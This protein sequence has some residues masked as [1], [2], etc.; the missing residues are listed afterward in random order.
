MSLTTFL[1]I[2][3]AVIVVLW[4]ITLSSSN[5]SN[6]PKQ[7][8]ALWCFAALS[9]VTVLSYMCFMHYSHSKNDTFYKNTDGCVLE[10]EGLEFS[11]GKTLP[12][13]SDSGDL[14]LWA[15]EEGDLVLKTDADGCFLNSSRLD[16]PLCVSD[17]ENTNLFHVVNLCEGLTLHDG[18]NLTIIES[19]QDKRDTLIS[20]KYEI[21]YAKKKGLRNLFKKK[22][23]RC[24]FVFGTG[25]VLTDTVE[26]SMFRRGRNLFNLLADEVGIGLNREVL[27]NCYLMRDHFTIDHAKD[28]EPDKAVHL[29]CNNSV[30]QNNAVQIFINGQRI[31]NYQPHDTLH[32]VD[33]CYFYTGIT[34]PTYKIWK[35]KREA[36]RVFVTY[37]NPLRYPFPKDAAY[38]RNKLFLTTNM[39]EIIDRQDDFNYFYRIMP[40]QVDN[41]P[42]AANGILSYQFDKANVNISPN[43]SDL[44]YGDSVRSVDAT[45]NG[46][47]FLL[48]SYAR[49][50]KASPLADVSYQLR[51]HDFRTD[52]I[53]YQKA[54]RHYIILLIA[55][56]CL[57]LILMRTGNNN[58]EDFRSQSLFLETAV[59]LV[60]IGFLTVRMIMLWRLH[61]FPPIEN[62]STYEYN[63]LLNPKYFRATWSAIYALLVLRVLL[64]LPSV[65]NIWDSIIEKFESAV[66][67]IWEGGTP[68]PVTYVIVALITALIIGFMYLLVFVGGTR[69][70]YL[71]TA[72]T[73]VLLCWITSII[74][75]H[76]NELTKFQ[77][78]LL[79]FLNCGIFLVLSLIFEAG[80]ILPVI[81]FFGLMLL[82]ILFGET[83]GKHKLA[84]IVV[85]FVTVSLS[86]FHLLAAKQVSPF[87]GKGSHRLEARMQAMVYEPTELFSDPNV[88]FKSRGNYMQDILNATSNY[89]FIGNHINYRNEILKKE[90]KGFHPV[91]E[92]TQK[93]VSYITQTRDLSLLRYLNFEH[94][95]GPVICLNVLLFILLL[96]VTTH[97]KPWKEED[98][99]R[100]LSR[101]L[102]LLTVLFLL[103]YSLY[104]ALV[105]VNALVFVGLDFPFLTLTS[106]A[107]P[108]AFIIFLLAIIW[109]ICSKENPE[110][111]LTEPFT[112]RTDKQNLYRISTLALSV[113]LIATVPL[114]IRNA[115]ALKTLPNYFV[116]MR[117]LIGFIRND[118]NPELLKYQEKHEK[119]FRSSDRVV[120]DT[121]LKKGVDSLFAANILSGCKDSIYY[122]PKDTAFI[123]SVFKKATSYSDLDYLVYA[124]KISGHY[125]FAGN[126]KF[127]YLGA[128]FEKQKEDI[129]HGDLLAADTKESIKPVVN[130]HTLNAINT[131]Q[132][133]P[134]NENMNEDRILYMSVFNLPGRYCYDGQN[135]LIYIIDDD[136]PSYTIIP[137]GDPS[138][139]LDKMVLSCLVFPKDIL[140]VGERSIQLGMTESHYLAKTIHYN[141]STQVIYPLGRDFT[142]A[143]N[144][145]TMLKNSY[146]AYDRINN[147]HGFKSSDTTVQ[148]SLD[149]ELLTDV[150][151]YCRGQESGGVTK[152]GTGLTVAAV[153]GN[154][155][156]RLLADY[157][158]SP[159]HRNIDPNDKEK[160]DEIMRNSV[161]NGER[162]AER[163]ALA[164][165]NISMLSNGPGSTI[166]P[167]LFAAIASQTNLDWPSFQIHGNNNKIDVEQGSSYWHYFGDYDMTAYVKKNETRKEIY[168]ERF[169]HA[170]HVDEFIKTSNN[171]FFGSVL[172]LGTALNEH[173]NSLTEMTG[174]YDKND[175]ASFP[176]FYFN[177]KWYKF[178]GDFIPTLFRTRSTLRESALEQ[179]LRFNFQYNCANA[180]YDKDDT[181][182]VN[183]VQNN[184]YMTKMADFLGID[185]PNEYVF[186]ETSNFIRK[187]YAKD[188][189]G[190]NKSDI[191]TQFLNIVRGGDP[192]RTSPLSMAEAFLRIAQGNSAPNLLTYCERDSAAA[193]AKFY[194]PGYSSDNVYWNAM[195]NTLFKGLWDVIAVGGGT[196]HRTGVLMD[197]QNS[198]AAKHIYLYGKTGTCNED[199]NHHYAFIL[200]NQKLNGSEP[201]DRST[202]KVYVVYFG[203]YD[204]PSNGHSA[205]QPVTKAIIE[206][207]INSETF[208][209]YWYGKN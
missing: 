71:K 109:P 75:T 4:M 28:P 111:I 103:V 203:F 178:N 185:R 49:Q 191:F 3:I 149:Y 200:T 22:K 64:E 55:F 127:S 159:S 163:N 192:V 182:V 199:K 96:I 137:Q 16:V 81:G 48:H 154:G 104:L 72:A 97:T 164:N 151:H 95:S 80:L 140:K 85:V 147:P 77:K 68:R 209:Q 60:L 139:E 122:T 117:P 19:S 61:A 186:P 130:G 168:G 128:I 181:I 176:A 5:N 36:G 41:S 142:F 89:W 98:Q 87:I 136:T 2:T 161:L 83:E 32:A 206:K 88:T 107:A 106:G 120:I 197:Y 144:F 172:M 94:G 133:V 50:Q 33:G 35:V 110:K 108:V 152:R 92:Y 202:L 131:D 53:V 26:P 14:S 45:V 17:P 123:H 7:K 93:G 31:S 30:R 195:R 194:C 155:C 44:S 193:Q 86:F 116:S 158:P 204:A 23:E 198:L 101:W 10:L 205:T 12:L 39:Q 179:G 129:W 145:Y 20:L 73:I 188:D 15:G 63:G 29:F 56:L 190:H 25:S 78:Y 143:A 102:P 42:F 90:Q 173:Q 141:G 175:K 38:G 11:E 184:L 21:F 167:V 24:R 74:L 58:K 118:L 51:V 114:G 171:Y 153:D 54:Q 6:N 113:L 79:V 207:I 150:L 57:F 66:T 121:L 13:V 166:K 165:R 9:V 134:L 162:D 37:R 125:S 18:D 177:N 91:Q 34:P 52:N 46:E 196:L 146:K 70:T 67:R 40:D 100:S 132:L 187:R 65:K 119:E 189:K 62:L 59:Y 174:G 8:T 156:V 183:E 1:V 47:H 112:F 69:F 170:M 115:K 124:R 126:L 27:E 105:N 208:K 76:R 148:I 180:K 201:V 43:Y 138:Q 160:L 82:I 135:K 169:D 84:L 99:E 157:N